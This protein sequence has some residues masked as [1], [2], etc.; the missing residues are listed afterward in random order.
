MAADGW[1]PAAWHTSPLRY[2]GS[3]LLWLVQYGLTLYRGMMQ[4]GLVCELCTSCAAHQRPRQCGHNLSATHQNLTQVTLVF[5]TLMSAGHNFILHLCCFCNWI[6]STFGLP[7]FLLIHQ[8]VNC[9]VTDK[10]N[11]KRL[12]LEPASQKFGAFVVEKHQLE[13]GAAIQPK[14]KIWT[15]NS[16]AWTLD[17][18]PLQG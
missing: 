15:I 5:E 16:G 13:G 4:F 2:V 14:K 9:S 3:A 12:T 6:Q 7:C 18:S 1:T 10:L 8:Q 17:T 11:L